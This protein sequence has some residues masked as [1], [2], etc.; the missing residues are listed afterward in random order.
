MAKLIRVNKADKER[1]LLTETLP[2]EVPILFSNDSFHSLLSKSI[3]KQDSVLESL[4]FND[5]PSFPF[6]YKIR[7]NCSS[8][9]NMGLPHPSA[10]IR[11]VDFYDKYQSLII[12]VC[13]RSR[14]SLRAPESIASHFSEKKGASRLLELFKD[15]LVENSDQHSVDNVNY[16]SSYFRYRDF[17]LLY[18]FFESYKFHKLER[19]FS[20]M[21]RGDISK[22]FP[23]IYTHS[24]PWAV[25]EK[26]FVKDNLQKIKNNTFE[27]HFDRLMQLSNG[28]ETNGIII[29]PEFSR[30]FSEILLQRIDQNVS[31]KAKQAGIEDFDI[32]R[33]VDDYFVFANSKESADAIMN[34]ISKELESYNLYLNESKFVLTE[35]PFITLES[36][37][38]EEAR[39]LLIEFFE[40]YINL[41]DKEEYEAD[42]FEPVKQKVNLRDISLNLTA[43]YKAVAKRAGGYESITNIT[44]T[45]IRN[46]LT[47]V[48]SCK[49]I[50][51]SY[52]RL[53]YFLRSLNRH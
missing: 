5:K 25:K 28:N 53:S 13:S 14:Y 30:I 9:R 27:G 1:I 41:P 48:A 8:S 46:N 10:Q 34:L 15:D 2:Y 32:R 16:A 7:K 42:D 6:K 38:K 36:I 29:G 22:C 50:G 52:G 4:F 47:K 21:L 3:L 20:V 12:S 19:K 35:R 39:S 18:K 24:I 23:S 33:Y 37:A 49:S 17:A 31:A 40:T 11:F 51:Q 44:L 45:L 26:Q 43:A